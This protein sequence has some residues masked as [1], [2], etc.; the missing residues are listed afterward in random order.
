MLDKDRLCDV[1]KAINQSHFLRLR[2]GTIKSVETSSNLD[3]VRNLKQINSPLASMAYLVL[4][5]HDL[6]RCSLLKA[7]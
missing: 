2:D 5:G 1:E 3:T 6:L 4:D 7:S